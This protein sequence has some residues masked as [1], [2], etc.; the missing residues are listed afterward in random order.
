[1]A[2]ERKFEGLVELFNV[3]VVEHRYVHRI[4]KSPVFTVTVENVAN[5][6]QKIRFE[7]DNDGIFLQYPLENKFSITVTTP[8]AALTQYLPDMEEQKEKVEHGKPR[9]K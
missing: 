2:A 4:S 8:Q 5:T 3:Q 1:M 7:A 6:K 9:N